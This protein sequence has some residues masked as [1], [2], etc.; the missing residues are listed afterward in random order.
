M[1]SRL[2]VKINN[3]LFSFFI[4]L[5]LIIS[6]ANLQLGSCAII[7][8]DGFESGNTSAWTG[9]TVTTGETAAANSTIKHTGSYSLK[10]TTN[11]GGG[12]ENA[13][14][15]YVFDVTQAELYLRSY[16]YIDTNGIDA[17]GDSIDFMRVR[18]GTTLLAHFGMRMTS[19]VV[20]WWAQCRSGT[21]YIDTYATSTAAPSTGQWYCIEGHW[22]NSSTAGGVELYVNGVSVLSTWTRDTDNYGNADR[23]MFGIAETSGVAASVTF[24]D[25]AFISTTY[26]GPET[27]SNLDSS[28]STGNN[29]AVAPKVTFNNN[30][31]YGLSESYSSLVQSSFKVNPQ[32]VTSPSFSANLVS[33][34]GLI[35]AFSSSFSWSSLPSSLFNL[36][37][38]WVTDF[39][40][41]STL[42]SIYNLIFGWVSSFSWV[43]N[44]YQI[45]GVKIVYLV[46]DFS[47]GFSWL[48]GASSVFNVLSVFTANIKWGLLVESTFSLVSQFTTNVSW[49]VNPQSMFNLITL[50][51][52]S[53]SWTLLSSEVAARIVQVVLSFST[54]YTWIIQVASTFNLSTV[55]SNAFSW[56]NNVNSLFNI[57]ISL[58]SGSTFN[59]KNLIDLVLQFTSSFSWVL[60]IATTVLPSHIINLVLLWVTNYTFQIVFP[61][62][63]DLTILIATGIVCAIL[64]GSIAL[65]LFLVWRKRDED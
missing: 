41:G 62:E 10:C 37:T 13:Y 2:T 15:S 38:S 40:F 47:S 29:F 30:V 4:I 21:S 9:T 11:G 31:S 12:T 16:V 3:K 6:F 55:F 54:A 39:N 27:T 60:N 35:A 51:I 14:V 7:F 56:V 65:V 28:F 18:V 33:T 49:L 5:I 43:A 34:F 36:L 61:F 45:I 53:F 22:K 8:N 42:Q 58:V 59:V 50:F 63:V 23:V 64:I 26:V 25:C 48:V 24:S 17:A 46:L 20:R 32:L 1:E 44:V 19:G 57:A 52:S